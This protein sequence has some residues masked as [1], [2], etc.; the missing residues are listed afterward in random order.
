VAPPGPTTSE[1]AVV[2]DELG[3]PAAD[4]GEMDSAAGDPSS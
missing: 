1:I 4:A 3:V 2:A